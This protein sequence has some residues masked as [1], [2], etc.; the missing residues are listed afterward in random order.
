MKN[1]INNLQNKSESV[2][3]LIMW[4]GI[5]LIMTAIFAFW[6]V[7]FPSQIPVSQNNEAT[8]NIKKELPGIWQAL[9]EQFNNLSNAKNIWQQR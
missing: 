4:S 3:H 5:F 6:L 1:F 8:D 2:K 7:T 9:K